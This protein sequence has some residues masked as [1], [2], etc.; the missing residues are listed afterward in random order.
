MK[1]GTLL[2][3]L[4]AVVVM[5]VGVSRVSGQE[6]VEDGR[7][8]DTQADGPCYDT[9]N[10]YVDCGNGTVTD[11]VTQLIWLKEATCPDLPGLG[12]PARGNWPTAM[13]AVAA[14]GEPMC[15]LS[16]GSQPG[17]WRLPTRDEWEATIARAVVL[18]CLVAGGNEPSLTNDAG[19]ACLK[20][21]PTSFTGIDNSDFW[22][23]NIRDLFVSAAAYGA[24][25]W[26]GE[27]DPY[28]KSSVSPSAWPVRRAP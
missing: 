27:V 25:V 3:A 2:L 22:S 21:G 20:V 13:A 11:T 14:L 28:T 12:T 23:S 9:T 18:G 4:V 7:P 16:D 26:H 24:S 17:D 1:L 15:G 10:R 5:A 8:V 6:L 19:T